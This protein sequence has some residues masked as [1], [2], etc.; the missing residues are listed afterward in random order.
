MQPARQ[1]HQQMLSPYRY[2][3]CHVQQQYLCARTR[4]S[5]LLLALHASRTYRGCGPGCVIPTT[6]D[7]GHQCAFMHT[8]AF[9]LMCSSRALCGVQEVVTALLSRAGSWWCLCALMTYAWSSAQVVVCIGGRTGGMGWRRRW[10][11]GP[12][13]LDS[14]GK[15]GSVQ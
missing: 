7:L 9:N 2:W 3:Q 12:E 13:S 15:W 8:D 14:V 10:E 1:H 4:C 5:L 11:R 6:E